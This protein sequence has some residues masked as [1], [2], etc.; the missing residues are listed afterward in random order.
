MTTEDLVFGLHTVNALLQ[1]APERIVQI[2]VQQGRDDQRV[3]LALDEARAHNVN[4]KALSRMELDKLFPGIKHQGI[5]AQCVK[6]KI[7]TEDDLEDL[8]DALDT[9]PF[10]LILDGVQDP[11]NLGACLRSAN[12]AGVHIVIAPADHS[13]GL[14]PVARKVASGAAEVTPFIQ[15]TNLARTLRKLKERGIWLFGACAEDATP[16]Y[17]ADLRGAVALVLGAEGQGLRRLTKEICDYLVVVPMH[18]SVESLNVS[19]A[20]G[21]CLFEALRQRNS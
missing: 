21:I 9:P 20:T 10:L 17:K 7:Y 12:A 8:L 3:R 16:I 1:Q 18:G 14:T 13:V 4:I 6:A 5:I 2:Y 19:V 15:V 11:H